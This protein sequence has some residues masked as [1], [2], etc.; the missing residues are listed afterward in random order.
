[1]RGHQGDR[2]AT[3]NTKAR[4]GVDTLLFRFMREIF[5]LEEEE[6][7]RSAMGSKLNWTNFHCNF[8]PFLR[9]D[10][11]NKIHCLAFIWRVVNFDPVYC[12]PNYRILEYRLYRVIIVWCPLWGPSLGLW[13]EWTF[14]QPGWAG[15]AQC[16]PIFLVPLEFLLSTLG[17]LPPATLIR[18]TTTPPPL[19]DFY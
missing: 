6:A 3:D 18:P 16:L 4:P 10:N 5:Q 13:T 14:P 15:W 8:Y 1:M 11:Q 19:H 12:W 17:H 7:A 2:I 9:Q